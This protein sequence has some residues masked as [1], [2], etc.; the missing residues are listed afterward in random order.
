VQSFQFDGVD[1]DFFKFGLM[2]GLSLLT[3]A[4]AA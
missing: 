1:Q 2:H 4:C 3:A